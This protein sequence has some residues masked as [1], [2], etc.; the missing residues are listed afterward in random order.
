MGVDVCEDVDEAVRGADVV[1]GLRLQLERQ[2]SG[3]F[4]SVREYARF[5]GVDR[6]RMGLAAKG[7]LLMHPGPVNRGVELSSAV[8][9]AP[10]STID[11]QVTNG[12][13]VR[14]AVLYLLAAR[15]PA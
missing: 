7:A 10:S 1:M 12:V 15:R 5:F 3:L 14:M 13:A 8:I 11:E 9:D 4:P 2:K 6:R